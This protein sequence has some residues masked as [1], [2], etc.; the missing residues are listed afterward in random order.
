MISHKYFLA[1]LEGKRQKAN[2]KGQRA[3]SE[4]GGNKGMKDCESILT[5]DMAEYYAMIQKAA[6]ERME[7]VKAEYVA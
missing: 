1:G 6:Y 5:G 7:P 4:K 2:V 3:K